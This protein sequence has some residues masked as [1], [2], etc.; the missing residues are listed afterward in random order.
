MIKIS[1]KE[2][3]EAGIHFGHQTRRWNPKMK[4]YIYTKRRGIHI[5]D[6]KQSAEKLQ[7][8]LHELYKIAASGEDV[9]FVCTKTGVNEIVAEQAMRCSMPYIKRRWLGGFLTNWTT[10]KQ[11]IKKL[12]TLIEER[13]SGQHDK[14][15]KKE[16]IMIS[17]EVDKL[18][19]FLGGVRNMKSTPGAIIVFD[20]SRDNIAVKEATHLNLPI[21]GV[22]DS[23]SNPEEVTFP[24][25]ANDD[26]LKSIEYLAT[27]FA[28][29]ILLAKE[30]KSKGPSKAAP[31]KGKDID[32]SDEALAEKG[33][34]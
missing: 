32:V 2:M 26:A 1:M 5:L 24:I 10:I 15:K 13:K 3:L 19:T 27:K 12:N 7:I 6:L 16:Q 29:V 22:S 21:I 23:N 31:A 33:D 11:R 8:A 30:K 14:Y 28:D 25:P 18:D 34:Q 20:I 9:V 17:R 4:Q